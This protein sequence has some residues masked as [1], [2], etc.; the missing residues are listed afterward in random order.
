MPAAELNAQEAAACAEYGDTVEV[1]IPN[2]EPS[3]DEL[4]DE[5]IKRMQERGTWKLWAFPPANKT[6]YDAESF[7]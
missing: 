4:F 7:K 5:G 6:F 3:M 2:L 1:P